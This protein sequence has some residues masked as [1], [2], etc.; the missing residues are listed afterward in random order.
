MTAAEVKRYVRA[1]L[2]VRECHD[3][4]G[5]WLIFCDELDKGWRDWQGAYDFTIAREKQIAEVEQEINWLTEAVEWMKLAVP[6]YETS[7][8]AALKRVLILEQAALADLKRG[9]R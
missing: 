8:E 4:E 7:C 1:H 2:R 3:E 9:M 6:Y 5:D